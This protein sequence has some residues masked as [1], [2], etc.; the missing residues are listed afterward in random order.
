ME[1]IDQVLQ[2]K[3]CRSGLKSPVC[4]PCGDTIC[5]KHTPKMR[6]TGGKC[7]VCG[8]V[9]KLEDGQHFPVNKIAE[10]LVHMRVRNKRDSDPIY[11]DTIDA[12]K[13]LLTSLARLNQIVRDIHVP[14]RSSIEMIQRVD[15]KLQK[16]KEKIN[17]VVIDQLLWKETTNEAVLLKAEIDDHTATLLYKPVQKVSF[18]LHNTAEYE[19][20]D[21]L[22]DDDLEYDPDAIRTYNR[23]PLYEEYESDEPREWRTS[24]RGHRRSH[25]YGYNRSNGSAVSYQASI[26]S[27]KRVMVQDQSYMK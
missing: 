4:L 20:D 17:R 16:M 11:Q 7:F 8:G 6:K 10:R 24:S 18:H 9:H 14:D 3:L 12:I 2:C 15:F 26:R 22:D 21:R 27:S 19:E 5:E 13:N 23:P 25:D 1:E